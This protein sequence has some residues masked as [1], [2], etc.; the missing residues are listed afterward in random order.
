MW[1]DSTRLTGPFLVLLRLGPD[2]ERLE[3]LCNGNLNSVAG[4][5]LSEPSLRLVVP[6][7]LPFMIGV[8]AR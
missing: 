6:L 3:H 2:P 5:E 4:L 7:L 8:Q 1:R